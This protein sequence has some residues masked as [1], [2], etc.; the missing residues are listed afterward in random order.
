MGK[1][2]DTMKAEMELR[3][4]A[5]STQDAYLRYAKQFVAHYRRPAEEM[6]E[7]E[8]RAFLLY[9]VRQQKAGDA[10]HKMFVAAIKF[11]Y[12]EALKRP[13]EVVG[14]PWPKV[15]RKLPDILSGSEVAALLS[16]ITSL[17]Q[18]AVVTTAYGAKMR[19]S[20]ACT[21]RIEDI[22]SAR[23]LIHIRQGK[24]K[25]DRYVMLAQRLLLCLRQYYRH[26]RPEGPLLFP[27][28]Q[29]DRPMCAKTVRKAVR[30]AVEACGIR[31]R[32]TPHSLRHAFATH[33]LETGTD[34]RTIQALL[35]H[36]SIRTTTVYTRV[37]RRHIGTVQSPLDVVGTDKGRVLG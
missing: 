1:T 18:R 27:G 25:K 36:S 13:E 28:R 11:L 8:I 5:P 3:R 2:Y 19:I 32:V 20:E 29:A 26:Q 31:K 22:D 33:L 37:S 35:G 14:I 24:R 10:R 34:L 9:V 12:A 16:A 17:K 21:L 7:R 4:Y 6:G 15:A 30:E 23:M